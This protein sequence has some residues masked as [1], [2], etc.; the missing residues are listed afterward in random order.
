MFNLSVRFLFCLFLNAF[1]LS[2]QHLSAQKIQNLSGHARDLSGKALSAI[3]AMVKE[4]PQ[5]PAIAYAIAD[6]SGYFEVKYDSDSDSI[7]LKVTG[8]SIE[9]TVLQLPNKSQ[10]VTLT[11][12]YRNHPL[13]EIVFKDSPSISKRGDTIIYDVSS[14]QKAQDRAVADV[15]SRMPGL[16]I[17]ADGTIEYQGEPIEKFYIE[18]LDLLGGRYSLASNNLPAQSVKSV[19]V[20][21]N[22]QPIRLLDSIAYSDK[23]SLNIRLM[24]KITTTGQV[25]ALAGV[26]ED[27]SLHEVNITPMFFNAK[28]QGIASLQSN[29]SGEEL[30]N[31]IRVLSKETILDDYIIPDNENPRVEIHKLSKPN[32]DNRRILFNSSHLGTLNVLRKLNNSF[33]A[34]AY[35]SYHTFRNKEYGASET[36]YLLPEDTVRVTEPTYNRYHTHHLEGEINLLKNDKN[37]YVR[38]LL[39]F[40]VKKSEQEGSTTFAGTTFNQDADLPFKSLSNQLIWL[41]PLGKQLVSLRSQVTLQ[42]TRHTLNVQPGLVSLSEGQPNPQHI[43]QSL[44]ERNVVAKHSAAYGHQFGKISFDGKLG[45]DYEYRAL[46]GSAIEHRNGVKQAVDDYRNNQE[47]FHYNAYYETKLVYKKRKLKLQL[48][49]PLSYQQVIARDEEEKVEQKPEKLFFNPTFRLT[50]TIN[51]FWEAYARISRQEKYILDDI[52]YNPILKNYRQKENYNS[53]IPKQSVNNAGV[54]ISYRNPLTSFFFNAGYSYARQHHNILYESIIS[55][56]GIINTNVVNQDNRARIQ[57]LRG[58]VSKFVDEINTTIR[59]DYALQESKRN[60]IINDALS[61]VTNRSITLSPGIDI[62]VSKYTS[63]SYSGSVKR[64]DVIIDHK[65]ANHVDQFLQTASLFVFPDK[66]QQISI[67]F[68]SYTNWFENRTTRQ[69]F[70]D[71]RYQYTFTR[72]RIDATLSIENIFNENSFVDYNQN[73]F[74]IYQTTYQ[75]RPR[76][77]LVGVKFGF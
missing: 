66:E 14:F 31:Q 59:L 18:G 33:E 32:F 76:Q 69:A 44:R 55:P 3:N 15:I 2:S 1:L 75:L 60:Q 5:G 23:T 40:N 36:V 71:L 39:Q 42:S 57:H 51:G 21:E 13:K 43:Q 12:D 29:N 52:H 35:I 28:T 63:L 73:T 48:A 58:Q 20:L 45:F 37:A 6:S 50:Y 62:N 72:P 9:D 64:A 68:D 54:N 24:N 74:T 17:R 27:E 4:E 30:G 41:R 77:F 19:E 67:S 61:M 46:S 11:L 10:Y 16:N 34:K 38:D 70:V 56:A 25:Q 26:N 53:A 8:Q 47:I 7:F 22:H 65:T 49:L